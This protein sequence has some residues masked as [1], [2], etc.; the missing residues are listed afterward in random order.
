[1]TGKADFADN[2]WEQVLEGTTSAGMLVITA[3]RGGTFRETI[4]MAKAYAEAREQHGSSELL[5]A[6]IAAK[7]KVDKA[8][9]GSPDELKQHYLTNIRE[10]VG[11][12][13]AHATPEELGEYKQFV[14]NLA[15][16]VAAAHRENGRDGDPVSDAEKAAITAI[17]GALG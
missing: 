2:E 9:S 5:D 16:K 17:Q 8:H 7:P 13:E 4:S 12:L 3:Q 10:A 11:L 14:V 1:M 15:N 6:I